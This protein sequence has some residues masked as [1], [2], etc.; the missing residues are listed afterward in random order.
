VLKRIVTTQFQDKR[1]YLR[2]ETFTRISVT[3]QL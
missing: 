3:G 2:P 1:N